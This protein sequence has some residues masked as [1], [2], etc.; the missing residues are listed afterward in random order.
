MS[1]EKDINQTKFRDEWHKASVNIIFTSNWVLEQQKKHFDRANLTQQQYNMLRILKGSPT[2]LS[3]LQIRER[4]LDKMSDT[5]RIVDRL[6]AKELVKKEVNKADK[7]LVDVTISIK[8]RE[9]IEW[10]DNYAY[11]I[12][13]VL[14]NL[15]EKEALQ[16]NALL[17]KAREKAE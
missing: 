1:I 7:R 5:S 4:M 9:L 16:L 12:D 6:V 2:P 14:K 3:T 11:E 13:D 8:G 17:D 15:S 10:M